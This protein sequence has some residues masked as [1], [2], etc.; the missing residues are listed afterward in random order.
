MLG[1]HPAMRSPA[2]LRYALAI[3][4][5]FM[6]R[7][8]V[9]A[10]ATPTGQRQALLVGC[11][12]YVNCQTIPELWGPA[13]DVPLMARL[14]TDPQHGFGF[15]AGDV[16]S[17]VGWPDDPTR[18]PIH[19]NITAAF[20]RLVARAAPGTQIF[21][22]MCGHGA[23]IPIP[24]SQPDAFDPANPEPDGLDEVFL[25]ADVKRWQE[26]KLD[27]ALL[28]NQIG[29]WLTEMRG[30][31]ADVWIVFDCC[32]SGSMS[33]GVALAERSRAVT[34][35]DLGIPEQAVEQAVSRAQAATGGQT[36][37]AAASKESATDL[38]AN[39]SVAKPSAGSIVAFYAAQ[40][41]ELAPEL[42]FP[43]DAPPTAANS[44]GL[45]SYN[46]AECLQQRASPLS[47]RGLKDLVVARY[48]AQRAARTP[49][50]LFEGDI[51]REVLGLRTW[52]ERG[53]ILLLRQDGKLRL[54]A[55]ELRGVLRG[56][57]VAVHPPAGNARPAGLV[58][59]H[60]KAI[61]TTAFSAEVEPCAH[62]SAAVPKASDL[63]DSARCE[64]VQ[65]ELG[66]LRIRL[67]TADPAPA[68]RTPS[69]VTP[70]SDDAT[71]T[72]ALALLPDEVKQML[73]GEAGRADPQWLLLRLTPATARD[74]YA[75]ELKEPR[76]ALIPMGS[77]MSGRPTAASGEAGPAEAGLGA[78]GPAVLYA[79]SPQD[80]AQGLAY[81][82]PKI[83][84]WQNVWRVAGAEQ[85]S[86][87]N[88]GLKFEVATL[89]AASDKSGGQLLR[90]TSLSPGQILEYRISNPGVENLWVTA[91]YLG[92]DF[93]IEV[94]YSG[95]VRAGAALKPIKVQITGDSTGPEGVVVFGVPM[96]VCKDEPDYRFLAQDRLGKRTRQRDVPV[97]AAKTPFE[98]LL[99]SAAFGKNAERG[100]RKIVPT[101]PVILS[102]SWV[103]LP[104][105]ATAKA[106]SK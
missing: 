45:L 50:P 44:Y 96:S 78:T 22:L 106:G 6:G 2:L 90:E 58:L 95:A 64:V 51:D 14:L 21:I 69:K 27:G 19:A 89:Q 102:K 57:I 1:W 59:G 82:L 71:L 61:S 33:R 42:T 101:N 52:P 88:V 74:V 25:P 24:E 34:S 39:S 9:A 83:F 93:S 94:Y 12:K 68:A 53:D 35:N 40:P 17:L 81:D 38:A 15:A 63:A 87:A 16:E 97:A 23:Q 62:D 49:T 99:R 43:K 103:T 46:L 55:G 36:R 100:S 30:K 75:L 31:G 26:G 66:D 29:K 91:I 37:G 32:H 67:T 84:T 4:L 86:P 3:A 98:A 85:A 41:W 10:D 56:S 5:L 48:R 28:D 77:G 92:A 54:S 18:R 72:A 13:N 73:A 47:Y 60:V 20:E 8:G 70:A 76:V 79:D 105:A 65:Q 7:S 104:R 80:I 11:T